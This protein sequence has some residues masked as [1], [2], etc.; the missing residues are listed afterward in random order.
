MPPKNSHNLKRNSKSK[1][2]STNASL[3]RSPRLNPLPSPPSSASSSEVSSDD[4]EDD[5]LDDVDFEDDELEVALG[6]QACLVNVLRDF[7]ASPDRAPVP[8]TL[9]FVGVLPPSPYDSL[10]LL[11]EEVVSRTRA[12]EAALSSAQAQIAALTPPDL[13]AISPVAPSDPTTPTNA[14]VSE[15]AKPRGFMST[16]NPLEEE[17]RVIR[18][19][20]NE[21]QCRFQ[22]LEAYAQALEDHALE[23]YSPS[24]AGILPPTLAPSYTSPS[25]PTTLLYSMTTAS[26][27]TANAN[28]PTTSPTVP[29]ACYTPPAPIATFT[30]TTTAPIAPLSLTLSASPTSLPTVLRPTAP[31]FLPATNSTVSPPTAIHSLIPTLPTHTV[32]PPTSPACRKRC[33]RRRRKRQ[34]PTTLSPPS[35]PIPTIQQS[36]Q[37]YYPPDLFARCPIGPGCHSFTWVE[38]RRCW[39]SPR[40]YPCTPLLPPQLTIP[41]SAPAW[42]G[43]RLQLLSCFLRALGYAL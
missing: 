20:H 9:P 29:T 34:A 18:I 5:E 26:S 3:R 39:S 4:F 22:E 17:L 14:Q 16:S 31:P 42:S 1:R 12:L 32:T 41:R 11:Y 6:H 2:I 10:V 38:A 36:P 35:L 19:S 13:P 8:N 7:F 23:C 24:S 21:L 43:P 30:P 15:S 37:Y 40:F 25:T 28:P 27:A 33:R